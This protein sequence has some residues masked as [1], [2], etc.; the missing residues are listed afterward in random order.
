V[1]ACVRCRHSRPGDCAETGHIER[2]HRASFIP[3]LIPIL[4][5]KLLSGKGKS[6]ENAEAR[7]GAVFSYV[8]GLTDPELVLFLDF[9][10]QPFLRSLAEVGDPCASALAGKTEVRT[11]T[12]AHAH[13]Q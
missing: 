5:A 1:R 10:L 8:G 4:C 9:L 13:A 11:R 12:T 7:R 3:L 6:K 2:R